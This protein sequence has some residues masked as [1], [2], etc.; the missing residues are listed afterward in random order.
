[1][2]VKLKHTNFGEFLEKLIC[3]AAGLILSLF[4]AS[5]ASASGGPT[6]RV[7]TIA[8]RG[9][10]RGGNGQP[11]W[12]EYNEKGEVIREIGEASGDPLEG[13]RVMAA[14][15]YRAYVE[16][17]RQTERMYRPNY[18]I[19]YRLNYESRTF[20]S[21]DGKIIHQPRLKSGTRSVVIRN[22]LFDNIDMIL[23]ESPLDLNRL[24]D[25]SSDKRAVLLSREGQ[26]LEQSS[27]NIGY[28]VAYYTPEGA[29][30]NVGST[31]QDSLWGYQKGDELWGPIGGATM[32]AFGGHYPS[33]SDQDGDYVV[34]Y[35]IPPCPGFSFQY[36]HHV[37]AQL[38]YQHFSPKQR[39][40]GA[41]YEWRPTFDYCMG[42][43]EAIAPTTLVGAVTKSVL[44]GIE[45][46]RV[47]PLYKIE[48]PVTAS[49]ITGEAVIK[50]EKR[51]GI[52]IDTSVVGIV[53]QGNTTYAFASP[54]FGPVARNNLDLDG[55]GKAD[56]ASLNAGGEVEL[57]LDGTNQATDPPDLAR[58][59]DIDPDIGDQ[60]LLTEID[61]YDLKSTDIF[62]YRVS[63]GQLINAQHG[64]TDDDISNS[65]DSLMNYRLLLRGFGFYGLN[66]WGFFD[67]FLSRTNLNPAF[68]DRQADHLRAGEQ[69]KVIMLNRATGYIGS[70][71]GIYGQNT[72][73][74]VVSFSPPQVEMHPPNLKIKAERRYEIEA[75]LTAGEEREFIIGFEGAGLT[76]DTLVAIT[77]EWFDW[78]GTP[79]PDDMPGL[80][81]RLA[82]VVAPNTLGQASSQIANFEIKPGLHTQ[83]I[84][85]P[86]PVLDTAHYYIHVSGES[87]QGTP[88][89][90]TT[91]AG[92]GP[93]QYRPKHYAPFMVPVFD[94]NATL[95]RQLARRAAIAAGQPDP[96]PVQTAY[97]WVYRPE[98]Q[99]SLFD[100]E[101]MAFVDDQKKEHDLLNPAAGNDP[102]SF[103]SLDF[104]YTLLADNLPALD[105]FGPGRELVFAAGGEEI[106]AMTNTADRR[107]EFKYPEH[108]M[109]LTSADL[110]TLQLYQNDDAANVLWAYA[111]ALV[112][113][114]IDSDNNN[115]FN[116]PDRT[117]T[118]DENE[119]IPA[120]P[121]RPGK[122]ICVN[123]HDTDADGVPNFADGFDMFG[124]EGAGAG[125]DFIPM[126]LELPESA[127]IGQAKIRFDYSQSDP[128]GL[129]R[130]GAGTPEDPYIYEPASG[131]LRIWKKPGSESRLKDEV[132]SGGDFIKPQSEY[133]VSD[134][135]PSSQPD[136]RQILLFIEGI[137][138]GTAI[139]DQ[140]VHVEVDLDGD[141]GPL[142]FIANDAVRLTVLN[143]DLDVDTNRDAHITDP[144]DE[145]GEEDWQNAR[146]A[147]F[148]VNFD[149]DDGDLEPDSVKF[150]DDGKP[151]EVNRTIDGVDDIEDITPLIIRKYG[152]DMPAA[153]SV[154]L[155]VP[156]KE[157][158]QS[159]HLYPKRKDGES[160]IWGSL[161][162]RIGGSAEDL[163]MDIS[164][165][166][167][168][169]YSGYIG[170][171][172]ADGD[173]EFGIEGLFFRFI[174]LHVIPEL[175]FDGE[176]DVQM[177]F[178]V[179]GDVI[180]SD[181]VRMRVAPWIML[182]RDQVSEAVWALEYRNL[183]AA[184]LYN[185]YAVPPYKGLDDSGQLEVESD[186]ADA[187]S[188]WFQDH[189]EIGYSQRPGG[190]ATHIIFRLPY[191]TNPQWPI[192]NM[193]EQDVGVF[194]LGGNLQGIHFSGDFGGNLE[195]LPPNSDFPIGRIVMGNSASDVIRQFLKSQ[196]YQ[197]PAFNI[198]VNWLG[199]AHIDEV[200]SFLPGGKVAISDAKLA[201]D[202]ME[203]LSPGE[204]DRAVLFAKGSQIRVD[205]V[206]ADSVDDTRIH[207]GIDHTLGPPFKYIRFFD[208]ASKGHVA[209]ILTLGNGFID[210]D[211]AWF[212]GLSI[213]DGVNNNID[214]ADYQALKAFYGSYQHPIQKL[215][216]TWPQAGDRYILLEDI[217][218]W[219]GKDDY[220]GD[221]IREGLP[222]AITVKEILDDTAYKSFTLNTVQ[223]TLN[224]IRNDLQAVSGG[225]LSFTE[226]PSLFLGEESANF[227][228][229]H[230]G[231]AFNPGPTN[232]QA[233]AG[234]LYVP[235]QFGPKNGSGQDIFELE[236]KNA[237]GM[238][239]EFVDDWIFYHRLDGEVHCGS[240][241][242]RELPADSWWEAISP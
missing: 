25:L 39:D 214:D 120:D 192:K 98:M 102:L 202:L 103:D 66:T 183:N 65:S 96:G 24:E 227:L 45:A 51:G 149:D 175:E 9:M 184:F 223:N 130:T 124:N 93:L 160:A 101:K 76:S 135:N 146:G 196:N 174:G 118:E 111:F 59:A 145:P 147:I 99:F 156:S 89:F 222:A 187:G 228:Y 63:N 200:T 142:G 64:L 197:V 179:N 16:A 234:K 237:L 125:G 127:D 115:A 129:M 15:T 82:K 41:Y 52:A 56:R 91:G 189:I 121:S 126:I 190:P 72:T 87:P 211:H 148:A 225:H 57:W 47:Q 232:L 100:L 176:I 28:L 199:V 68:G 94:E 79:L 48:F 136:E 167:N 61:Q 240:N 8:V 231:V 78:D 4:A 150:K 110:L 20:A 109:L 204:K 116:E 86:T 236:I 13:A 19:L 164:L 75:G 74:G 207:T 241:V 83:L 163:E 139:A 203:A 44:I 62:V 90:S 128:A 1:M 154:F 50:N 131:N 55:D 158:I 81:G 239:V 53:P 32:R 6:F 168:P 58:L 165:W 113:L 54:T 17:F 26:V 159:I 224:D 215:W 7:G 21:P 182:S 212:T 166:V 73:A 95:D 186:Y 123:A 122:I 205:T 178:R 114:D 108:L 161:G 137:D 30:G 43:S 37:S 105:A 208:G 229:E 31:G 233:V 213:N 151:A 195:V 140:V 220:D 34:Y 112:D 69:I 92:T 191:G 226:V 36:P 12:A 173:H 172:N 71:I 49:I 230:T 171:T 216:V 209:R 188:Q 18:E 14:D 238:N 117:M 201:W 152:P 85:L 221:G 138:Q 46:S 84:K 157:D 22:P 97:Q 67:T 77:T 170:E 60:G 35:I 206:M 11:I 181:K 133:S 219:V 33:V 144:D 70:A 23:H 155:K 80:T 104:V 242:K 193:L 180:G 106:L 194:Q 10:V 5:N 235:R 107:L 217:L 143:L 119:N 40:K 134:L 2:K 153:V 3:M 141:N 162:D 198:Q 169:N 29:S 42:F 185:A 218:F 177:E 88:D 210:I 27:E 38:R 132:L